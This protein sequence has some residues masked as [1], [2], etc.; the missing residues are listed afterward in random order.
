MADIHIIPA[1]SN[2]HSVGHLI[3]LLAG[4]MAQGVDLGSRK[5]H[6]TALASSLEDGLA[7]LR[8][9]A[10]MLRASPVR[11]RLRLDTMEADIVRLDACVAELIAL[12][13]PQGNEIL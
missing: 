1:R 3:A 7:K 11:D 10:D 9:M 2:A 4:A 8:L 6:I 13:K 5:H 12:T